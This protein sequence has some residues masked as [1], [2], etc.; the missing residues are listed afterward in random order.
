MRN[1]IEDIDVLNIEI[2]YE[3]RIE[4]EDDIEYNIKIDLK[5]ENKEK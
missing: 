4:D 2:R 1:R 3:D 5:K